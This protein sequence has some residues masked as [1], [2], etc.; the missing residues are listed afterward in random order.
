MYPP[1]A[2][3]A[4]FGQQPWAAF[5]AVPI[6]P[7]VANTQ[8]LHLGNVESNGMVLG[9]LNPEYLRLAQ[10]T[11]HSSVLSGSSVIPTSASYG[12]HQSVGYSLQPPVDSNLPSRQMPTVNLPHSYPFPQFNQHGH[13]SQ[14]LPLSNASIQYGQSFPYLQ[15]VLPSL[16]N[17]GLSHLQQCTHL[18]S[19]SQGGL[20][21]TPEACVQKFDPVRHFGT[22][23]LDQNRRSK[24][25][26]TSRTNLYIS[27]LNES[28]TDETVRCLV[29]DVVQPK[30]CKAMVS[31]GTCKGYGFIDCSTEEDAE[32]AKNH[33]IEYAK[34]S[35]RKLLVKFAHENEKDMY[36]V[37]VRHLPLDFTKEK[38]E[39]L[40]CK[41]GQ[42]TSVKLLENEDRL[43]GI[44]FVRFALAE[45]ADRAIEQMNAEKLVLGDNTAPVMCKLADKA[46]TR[47]R[48]I[49]SAHS[50]AALII[51]N[52]LSLN[53]QFPRQPIQLTNPTSFQRGALSLTQQSNPF[54]QSFSLTTPLLPQLN[55]P[56]VIFQS[57][58]T[59]AASPHTR[60]VLSSGL[61]PNGTSGPVSMIPI[62]FPAIPP[63]PLNTSCSVVSN[64]A[65]PLIGPPP[66]GQIPSN[67]NSHGVVT[68]TY[69]TT[70][71]LGH[72]TPKTPVSLSSRIPGVSVCPSY[73]FVDGVVAG[74]HSSSD[75][76]TA[77]HLCSSS[78]LQYAPSLPQ[79]QTSIYSNPQLMIFA[80]STA[81]CALPTGSTLSSHS[82][83]SFAQ[84]QQG[85]QQLDSIKTSPPL[86]TSVVYRQPGHHGTAEM[87]TP[88]R[89]V[90]SGLQTMSLEASAPECFTSLDTPLNPT[91]H[92]C[93]SGDAINPH[94]AG[95][96]CSKL[97]NVSAPTEGHLVA[98][99][100]SGH[101]LNTGT[102][103]TGFGDLTSHDLIITDVPCTSVTDSPVVATALDS[104]GSTSSSCTSELNPA[105]GTNQ[106]LNGEEY[107]GGVKDCSCNDLES[108]ADPA[109]QAH[110]GGVSCD[111][112]RCQSQCIHR[113]KPLHTDPWATPNDRISDIHD[114]SP[115]HVLPATTSPLHS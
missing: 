108:P 59:P 70:P 110:A 115:S 23:P 5:T 41:F 62:S 42:I 76:S 85:F 35:G 21:A 74:H 57:V 68:T 44:G 8:Q 28:D 88:I 77:V 98:T 104:G 66:Q 17:G 53:S 15:P 40:F 18:H 47:R 12:L 43:T 31:N 109:P 89:L 9:T 32:K 93:A 10:N 20:V 81:G 48:A 79:S 39:E 7:T 101:S 45:Q 80:Q 19:Q 100:S 92:T 37:Y 36:N 87:A 25:M 1:G 34:A 50:A 69:M 111:G 49:T 71:D 102:S 54:M 61:L 83:T 63:G 90:S 99:H 46:N 72:N 78:T 56:H 60:G 82:G 30:S 29:K 106:Q 114:V 113:K 64:R 105:L 14:S 86:P 95:G 107:P 4:G 91:W 3:V 52:Q 67:Q 58:Q 103:K 13:G 22:L 38:L 73:V 2:S 51:Q 26:I 11:P 55:Q 27:G 75:L 65:T 16:C 96:H 33:I 6:P 84:P 94:S 24:P 112:K 97:L